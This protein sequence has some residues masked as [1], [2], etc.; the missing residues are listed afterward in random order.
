MLIIDSSSVLSF[1][2]QLR[3][4]PKDLRP[5]M[6]KSIIRGGDRI[7]NIWRCRSVEPG[8]PDE[9]KHE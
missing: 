4:V 9:D 8:E 1:S 7:V 6:R 3:D 2:T 5:E